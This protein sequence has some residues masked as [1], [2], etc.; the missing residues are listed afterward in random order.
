MYTYHKPLAQGATSWECGKRRSGRCQARLHLSA[1]DECIASINE[2]SHPSS[3][4]Q[5]EVA[6]VKANIKR[7][8]ETTNETTQHV[9]AGEIMGILEGTAA[10]FPSLH[11][12]RRTIR[13]QRTSN[14][15]LPPAKVL[16]NHRY[17]SG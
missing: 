3:D 7:R 15:N 11:H 1:T 2:H 6:K 9:L 12:I 17:H 14:E 10:L 4:V 16:A 5:C 8:A 13:S